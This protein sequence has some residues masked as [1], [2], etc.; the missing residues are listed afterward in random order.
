[1]AKSNPGVE[2]RLKSKASKFQASLSKKFHWDFDQDL[3][4]DAPVV[5]ELSDEQAT[6]VS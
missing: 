6:F 2:P 4:D 1:M 5:V 3:D